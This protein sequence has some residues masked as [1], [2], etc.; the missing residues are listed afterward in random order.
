[1]GVIATIPDLFGNQVKSIEFEETHERVADLSDPGTGKTRV[2]LE[3]FAKRRARGA[4][5]LLVLAPKSLLHSAWVAD[6]R[7]YTPWLTTSAAYADNREKAFARQAD[8][9]IT[10][11]DA[12]KWLAKQPDSFFARFS[13]LCIDESGAFKH[14][15]SQRSKALAKIKR[16]FARRTIMNGTLTTNGVTD[17]WHQVHILDDGQ[18]LGKSFYAFRQ[19]VCTP[20]QVGPATNMVKWD[21]RE[22]A[23]RV[24]ADLIKDITI[25]HELKDCVDIPE[26]HKFVVPYEMPGKVEKVYREMEKAA[27]A[28]M[29]DG[30]LVEG[31]NA[32]AVVT[33]LLQIASGA[34]YDSER[35]YHV[36]DPSRYELVMDLAEERK[37]VVVFFLWQH[38][39]DL[40]VKE[41]EA[42]GLTY[43]VID[44]DASR[45]KR[46]ESV[47]FYQAGMYRVMFAQPQSAAHGLTLTKGTRT[48][49]ASPT[50]NLE[51]WIQ[52]N[53]RIDRAG[54]TEKTETANVLAEGTIE[55][56]V[57]SVM[58]QKRGKLQD[59][60]EYLRK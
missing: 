42:R 23:E 56:H 25:R 37:H 17:A 26:N 34:V 27:V 9:Y 6:C 11:H 29:K 2:R 39:R 43:T 44:G 21:D 49:W 45:K 14:H 30:T 1:V 22:G 28:Q 51:H 38:Q 60:L 58:T 8:I 31:I 35:N 50:Y 48:I 7:R 10:N 3:A 5:C 18:R 53:H 59:L 13:E 16:H 54:Q 32:A 33:K 15:T 41:A 24:V 36:I 46:Q 55:E 19:A 40:L 12:V 47:E 20:R 52:G 57:Y 4:K